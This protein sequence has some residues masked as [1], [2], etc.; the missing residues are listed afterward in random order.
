MS[1]MAGWLAIA[2]ALLALVPSIVP[3][4]I[5]VFGLIISM[6]ALV[7]SLFSI[8]KTGTKYFRRTAIIVLIGVFLVNDGLR[9]W[10]ALPMPIH[11]KLSLYVILFFVFVACVLMAYKLN[12]THSGI[13]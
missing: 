6:L 8:K 9:I 13:I 5:S 11:I 7:L 3:G 4:V 1:V 10:D 2:L 12:P